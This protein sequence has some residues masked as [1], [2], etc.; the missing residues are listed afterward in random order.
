MLTGVGVILSTLPVTLAWQVRG[1]SLAEGTWGCLAPPRALRLGARWLSARRGRSSPTPSSFTLPLPSF[2]P[3]A[4]NSSP[5]VSPSLLLPRSP[6]PRSLRRAR[7][8]ASWSAGVDARAQLRGAGRVGRASSCCRKNPSAAGAAGVGTAP[9]R[10]A[11]D[12]GP[13]LC[14]CPIPR[15]VVNLPVRHRSSAPAR[16]E[17]RREPGHLCVQPGGESWELRALSLRGLGLQVANF[18]NS[19]GYRCG[20]LGVIASWRKVGEAAGSRRRDPWASAPPAATSTWSS[21]ALLRSYHQPAPGSGSTWCDP[22]VW[23]ATA[24]GTQGPGPGGGDPRVKG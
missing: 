3:L 19:G 23:A 6:P 17:G 2:S 14:G 10:R 5:T 20:G 15:Q 13:F 22:R 1:R 7:S 12:R 18:S 11:K 24:M 4:P 9:E 21:S 8:G 16:A